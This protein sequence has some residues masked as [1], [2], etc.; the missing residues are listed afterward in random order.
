MIALFEKYVVADGK[1]VAVYSNI[2]IEFLN[3][4][5]DFY[6]AKYRIRYRGPRKHRIASYYNRAGTCLKRDARTFS[7]YLQA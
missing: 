5:R 1:F 6:G 4:F 7:A 2:P 3:Q